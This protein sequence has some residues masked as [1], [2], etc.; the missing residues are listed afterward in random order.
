MK[1]SRCDV[2]DERIFFMMTRIILNFDC[3][4]PGESVIAYFPSNQQSQFSM[5]QWL[6]LAFLACFFELKSILGLKHKI[7]Y[8]IEP[9]DCSAQWWSFC[10]KF[11]DLCIAIT[12]FSLWYVLKWLF[13]CHTLNFWGRACKKFW[14]FL[15]QHVTRQVFCIKVWNQFAKYLHSV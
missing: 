2:D 11:K 14:M 13:Y 3:G 15:P 7:V 12:I 4:L 5:W 1:V 8:N 10:C 9:A 6:Y